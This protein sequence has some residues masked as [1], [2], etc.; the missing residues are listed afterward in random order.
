MATRGDQL[1]GDA[2]DQPARHAEMAAAVEDAEQQA[3]VDPRAGRGDG[4]ERVNAHDRDE[5]E[6]GD[7]AAAPSTLIAIRT[8][9]L[10]SLRA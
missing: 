5:G 6:I 9:V 10:T 8:G 4:G 7:D 3:E 2:A 1:L